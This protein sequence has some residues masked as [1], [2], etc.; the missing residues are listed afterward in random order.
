M[1]RPVDANAVADAIGDALAYMLGA[2]SEGSSGESLTDAQII[3][4]T[5]ATVIANL[6]RHVSDRGAFAR[7]VDAAE[8]DARVMYW[9]GK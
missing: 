4:S 5:I 3:E 9:G 6:N 2:F 7:R 1:L 8:A